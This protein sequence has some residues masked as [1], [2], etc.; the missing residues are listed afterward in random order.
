MNAGFS[1]PAAKCELNEAPE[2]GTLTR[3]HM[4]VY[5]AN[6]H[7]PRT[8]PRPPPQLPVASAIPP[9]PKGRGRASGM[10]SVERRA[11][12]TMDCIYWPRWE[13]ILWG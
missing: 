6:T 2:V 7:V 1:R 4:C 13:G 8:G 3:C 11:A 10:R 5:E 9:L 12:W